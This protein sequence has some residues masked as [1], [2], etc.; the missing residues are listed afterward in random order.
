MSKPVERTCEIVVGYVS[1]WN[2]ARASPYIRTVGCF[3]SINI[4][5]QR[6]TCTDCHLHQLQL[7]CV[8][9]GSRIFGSQHG[10]RRTCSACQ[11]VQRTVN[12]HDHPLISD[13][14][15]CAKSKT[16]E[17]GCDF[18]LDGGEASASRR[19]RLA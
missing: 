5:A 10:V 4:A 3:R 7:V 1:D 19:G 8:V 15:H 12:I 14:T 6:I 18:H 9:D 13:P 16:R 17:A 11:I 2:E